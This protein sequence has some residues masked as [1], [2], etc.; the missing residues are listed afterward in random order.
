MSNKKNKKAEKKKAKRLELLA[1]IG[2]SV[3]VVAICAL[4]IFLVLKYDIGAESDAG[5]TDQN[6]TEAPTSGPL[7]VSDEGYE[8]YK[9][10][11]ASNVKTE[12]K[13]F[14]TQ[15]TGAGIYVDMGKVEEQVNAYSKEDFARS[16]GTTDF[17]VIRFK[18]LGDVIIAL[19]DD[20]APETV[21]NFKMLASKGFYSN[22]VIS[23]IKDY[24]IE[25]GS[26]STTGE[27]KS[28]TSIA[29][30][31]SNNG[32]QNN[33]SHVQGVISMGRLGDR[34]SA[35]SA[36]FICTD[37]AEGLDNLYASFG[38]VVAG[39]DVVEKI[40]RYERKNEDSES[41]SAPKDSVV[42]KEVFFVEPKS[43]KN[44]GASDKPESSFE[45]KTIRFVDEDLIPVKDLFPD[46]VIITMQKNTDDGWVDV[47]VKLRPNASGAAK[48]SLEVGDYR[49]YVK[50]VSGDFSFDEFYNLPAGQETIKITVK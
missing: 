25:G 19:R 29:G 43:D 35:S 8:Y 30:E 27:T 50:V 26:L 45:N 39:Y 48:V 33:L 14:D 37:T 11:T 32:Y 16:E 23:N 46:K 7:D 28:A 17:A 42:I 49:I 44:L 20:I 13:Y 22:T 5:T 15:T 9:Y 4:L 21:N 40:S 31:F 6:A 18:N 12:G 36:F 47:P 1:M 34:D 38:Y 41:G 3:L 10:D 2:V 24:F